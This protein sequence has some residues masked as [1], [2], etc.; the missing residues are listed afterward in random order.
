MTYRADEFSFLHILFYTINAVC[1]VLMQKISFHF[2]PF[3]LATAL[4][5]HKNYTMTVVAEC[6]NCLGIVFEVLPPWLS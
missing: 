5:I 6:L 3:D 2:L 1:S 4:S